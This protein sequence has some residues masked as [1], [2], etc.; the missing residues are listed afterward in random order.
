MASALAGTVVLVTRPA[1]QAAS[2]CAG[3][4]SQGGIA[5][6]APMLAIQVLTS[7]LQRERIA[8]LANY[9]I[10]IF[11]S[12]NAVDFGLKRLSQCG[13][14]ITRQHLFAVGNGTAQRLRDSGHSD[15]SIPTSAFTSD[16][17]LELGALQEAS[18]R[19]TK[20]LIFRGAGGREQLGQ[21]LKAR[22]A[23]VDYCEVYER[24]MPSLCIADTLA[25][26]A[27]TTPNIGVVTSLHALRNF[28]LKIGEEGLD[29][30][31]RMPLLVVG[32]RIAVEVA[33]LGFTQQPV[34]VDNPSDSTIINTLTGWVTDEL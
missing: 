26:A 16:G 11:I 4:E 32:R 34:L 22:G 1:T 30:L 18:I 5:I 7:A 19:G 17:L 23:S 10:I 33:N 31:Y 25:R 13:I 6:R 8:L 24:T 12:R 27:I 15:V 2:L 3:I 9:A 14:Q 20:I 29:E 28:A 21:T